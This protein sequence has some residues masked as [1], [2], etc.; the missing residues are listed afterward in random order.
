MNE[1]VKYTA[2]QRMFLEV[3]LFLSNFLYVLCENSY[4]KYMKI[5]GKVNTDFTSDFINE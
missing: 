4:Y 5:I 1:V 2:N 3:I